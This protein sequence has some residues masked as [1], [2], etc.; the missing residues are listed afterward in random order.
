MDNHLYKVDSDPS[1]TQ[2]VWFLSR[3]Q[4]SKSRPYGRST[5]SVSKGGIVHGS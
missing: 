1:N 3:L 4:R 2:R 5:D